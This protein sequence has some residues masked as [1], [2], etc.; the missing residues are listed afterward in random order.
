MICVCGFKYTTTNSFYILHHPLDER[1]LNLARKRISPYGLT[2]RLSR[3][4]SAPYVM[5]YNGNVNL[6]HFPSSYLLWKGVKRK[7]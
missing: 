7:R 1:E 3:P 5:K 6:G 4:R 2:T